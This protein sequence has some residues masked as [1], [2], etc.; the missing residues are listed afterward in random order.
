MNVDLSP[1]CSP[2]MVCDL[3]SLPWPW[4]DDSIEAVY[5][6]HSLEHLGQS[7]RTFLGIMKELYRICRNDAVIE[8]N[9]PHPRHDNF[10][11]DPTHVR[12]IT[13]ELL[14]LFD[15]QLNDEWKRQRVANT[16]LAHYLD[17]D[18]VL[19]STRMVLEEPYSAQYAD[20][21]LSDADLATMSREMNNVISELKMSIVARKP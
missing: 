7:S 12:I 20:G 1:V 6:N 16:P 2:D 3:E 4:P 11:N 13:P 5:F 14:R 15:R 19:R 10:I 9:V 8:I 17:V 18:F 21:L